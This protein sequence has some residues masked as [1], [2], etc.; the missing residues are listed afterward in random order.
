[1]A[2]RLT[3]TRLG[4]TERLV[5]SS[6][7]SSEAASPT[8][9]DRGDASRPQQQ[10]LLRAS[11]KLAD[12]GLIDR[13]RVYREGRVRDRRRERPYFADGRSCLR[14]DPSRRH[15]ASRIAIR[16]TPF[17]EEIYQEFIAELRM[18]RAIRWD[19]RRVERAERIASRTGPMVHP[20]GQHDDRLRPP[21]LAEEEA[22]GGRTE[23]MPAQ[24]G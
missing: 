14:E 24:I 20:T 22:R 8:L 18:G 2:N 1:M 19:D 15:F 17:G 3:G 13:R 7:A 4:K 21:S 5:Y 12:A 10:G 6:A 9:L 23:Y 16:K 11:K